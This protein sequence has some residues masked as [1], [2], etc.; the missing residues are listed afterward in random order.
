MGLTTFFFMFAFI[1]LVH[2]KPL[3]VFISMSCAMATLGL[4]LTQRRPINRNRERAGYVYLIQS[5]TG[6]Y[7]IGR[8][9]DINRRI[10]TFHVKL[11]FEI[12]PIC[13]IKTENMFVLEAQLHIKF[14]L[15]RLDGE[16]FKLTTEDVEYIKSLS[17]EQP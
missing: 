11:P 10:K 7:K 8:T 2:D 16:W 14:A 17:K 4:H 9:I 5:P 6:A 1:P 3:G 12:E 15:K 13:I